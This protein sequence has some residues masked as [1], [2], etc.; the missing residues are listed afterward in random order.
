MSN[1]NNEAGAGPC[2]TF[3]G[4]IFG[5]LLLPLMLVS[6]LVYVVA[7]PLSLCCPGV[8]CIAWLVETV[9]WVMELPLRIGKG[10]AESCPC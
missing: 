7:F 9:L 2:G 1:E 8:H 4:C 5:L 3:F 10:I 6:V